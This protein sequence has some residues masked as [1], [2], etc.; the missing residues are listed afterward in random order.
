MDNQNQP[1]D[2]SLQSIEPLKTFEPTPMPSQPSQANPST[3]PVLMD[4]DGNVN[5][6]QIQDADRAKYEMVANAIDET[7]P[8]SIVNF[9]SELQKNFSQSE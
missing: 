3:P 6:N 2:P 7:N 1:V 8:G 5:L 4:R 9:G